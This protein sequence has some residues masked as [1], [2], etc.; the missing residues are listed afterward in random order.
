[1]DRSVVLCGLGRVGWRV[2][3]SLRA[4]GQPVA[5]VDTHPPLDDPRLAGLTVVVGDCRK[6]EVLE[7][8]GVGGA[9]AVLIVT[10]DDLVNVSAALIVRQLNADVRVVLRMFNQNLLDRLGAAVKNTTALSVS[11]LV[12]PLLALTAATGE[13]LGAFKLDSGPQQIAELVVADGT[14]LAGRPLADVAGQY[15]VVPL[16]VGADGAEPRFLLDVRGDTRLSVGDRLV[17]AG[18]PAAVRPL[19]ETVRGDL[20]PGVRWA[21]AV[22][23]WL[24][25]AVT[26]L[27]EVDLAVKVITPVLFVALLASTLTFRYGLESSWAD[28]VY[29]SV[30]VMATG[31]EL[32]GDA[33]PEWAKVFLSVLKLVGAALLAGFTAILTNYLIRA[34]LGGALEV[35]RVPDG[36]HVVV[37]GLGNLGYRCV[38]ALTAIGERVV[39]IDRTNDNPFIATCRRKGVPAFVGDATV[40]EVLRQARADT[41]KAV[42]AATDS[43]LA[44]LEIALL[45]KE[46]APKARLVVRLS[47]P[48]FA[49]ALRESAGVRHAVSEP[50]L[51]APAFAAALFG[52]RVQTLVRAIG[53]TLVVVEFSPQPDGCGLA[54]KSLRAAAVDYRF[55]PLS[56]NGQNPAT[57]PDRRLKPGDRVTAVAELPDLERLLR[58]APVAKD[59]RVVVDGFPKTA[60]EALLPLV[61]A[62]RRCSQDEADA[63]L[64]APPFVAADGL[65]RGEA[66]ELLAQLGR[67]RVTA[68]AE[69]G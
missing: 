21:G 36:G 67:E 11:G 23:R 51:A 64:A 39:A 61:R 13:A 48:L 57:M 1:M 27:G 37:C 69:V 47:D 63:V 54:G 35:R 58:R 52:D 2:L 65:T 50:A 28:G 33:R 5:V 8:A 56:L 41:A 34:R 66:D 38:E 4:A 68:R 3:E 59:R 25:T 46:F 20:L 6:P 31:A 43:E 16:A 53:R 45:V 10:G 12:A 19:L 62:A 15:G 9:A 29:Q 14:D 7:R 22:R 32:R 24:R 40:A 18:A 49:G 30:S 26:T 44:N 60:R 17:V 55:L 42:I